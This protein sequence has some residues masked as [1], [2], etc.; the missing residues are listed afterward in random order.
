MADY[1]QCE[2]C[3]FFT[4]PRADGRQCQKHQ[5]VMPSIDWQ[6]VCKD[7]R[8][9][10]KRLR[11]SLSEQTLYYY[12]YGSGQI[13]KAPIAHFDQ[14][15]NPLVSVTLRRDEE[16]GWVIYPRQY[17]HYFPRAGESFSVFIGEQAYRFHSVHEARNV[18]AAMT[19]MGD[20][21]WE[22]NYHE[23][24]IYMLY[25]DADP[26]LLYRWA[27]Q[28]LDFDAYMRDCFVPNLFAFVEVIRQGAQY[29]LH[30]DLLAYQAYIR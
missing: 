22:M 29:A 3:Q 1:P 25:H 18:A 19:A 15:Q 6:M 27:N 4:G 28:M 20:N 10:R 8:N 11:L 13:R 7:W 30:P 12:S 21:V 16:L 5:F 24:Y 23:Q 9:D 14:L 26:N 17:I 2:N